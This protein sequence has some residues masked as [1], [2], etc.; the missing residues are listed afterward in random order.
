MSL[1]Q[2]IAFPSVLNC[3]QSSK[4]LFDLA[5]FFREESLV[6]VDLLAFE[7]YVHTMERLFQFRKSRACV[8]GIFFHSP[9]DQRHSSLLIHWPEDSATYIPFGCP[10]GSIDSS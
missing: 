1:N 6:D 2:A 4:L 3:Q 9:I 5:P 10:M 7:W 8:P